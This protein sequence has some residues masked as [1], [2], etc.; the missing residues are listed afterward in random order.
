MLRDPEAS[1]AVEKVAVPVLS[2]AVSRTLPLLVSVKVTEPA[3]VPLAAL[4]IAVKVSHESGVTDV[5]DD[6]SV[7]VVAI[8]ACDDV[9]AAA[10]G[11]AKPTA[12]T[13]VEPAK[14]RRPQR[15]VAHLPSAGRVTERLSRINSEQPKAGRRRTCCGRPSRRTGS[16]LRPLGTSSP[17]LRS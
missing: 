14:T 6:V 11:R 2:S 10:A 7:V 15:M 13:M 5:E 1:A 17:A 12:A 9:V 8:N 4:T 16:R 3:G